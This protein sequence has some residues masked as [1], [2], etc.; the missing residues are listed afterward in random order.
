[1]AQYP[2]LLLAPELLCGIG[3]ET[4]SCVSKEAIVTGD[5]Q[6]LDVFR[7]LH[8]KTPVSIIM[9]VRPSPNT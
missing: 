9:S 6:F 5:L 1:L 4:V 8:R 3:L 7:K 2:V